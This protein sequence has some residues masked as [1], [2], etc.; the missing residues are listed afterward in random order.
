MASGIRDL[1]TEETEEVGGG[2]TEVEHG[3]L[4]SLQT[5]SQQLTYLMSAVDSVI[6]DISAR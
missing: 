4:T 1:T 2:F 3:D 5:A 6:R